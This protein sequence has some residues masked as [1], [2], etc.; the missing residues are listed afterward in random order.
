MAITIKDIAN[1]TGFSPATVS[2]VLNNK[3]CRIPEKTRK[4][5]LDIAEKHQYVPNLSAR[6]LVMKQSKTLG[7]IIPDISNPYFAEFAKG[8][9]KEAQ[10]NDYSVIFCNSN[11]SGKKD[12]SNFKILASRQID[13]LVIVTS[14]HE[15]E[16]KFENFDYDYLASQFVLEDTEVTGSNML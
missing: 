14:I 11:D 5:I 8:V 13:G 16:I 3:K 9:E 12:N 4:I 7:L 15:N 1:E 6:A 10:K 2:L